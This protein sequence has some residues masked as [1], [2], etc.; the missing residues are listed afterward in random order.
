[1]K[2]LLFSFLVFLS[3]NGVVYAFDGY[4]TPPSM[5]DAG[6]INARNLQM[7]RDQQFKR[8]EIKDAESIQDIKDNYAKELE[9]DS[10]NE[11]QLFNRIINGGSSRF[12]EDEGKIKIQ[13][14]E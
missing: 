6:S 9:Q 1:M 14:I 4:I 13:S 11:R 2:K 3:L 8:Q 12:V 5:Y 7:L 10:I